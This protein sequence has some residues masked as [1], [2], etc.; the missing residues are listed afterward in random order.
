MATKGTVFDIKRFAIH[1]GPGIRTIVFLKG[2]PLRCPW[3]QNPESMLL[4]PELFF[5]GDACTGCGTCAEA[6]TKGAVRFIDGRRTYVRENCVTCGECSRQCP[7][8]ALTLVGR[9]MDSDEVA[10]VVERDRPFYDKSGGGVT[11]SGGEPLLQKQFAKEILKASHERGI[12]TALDTCAVGRWEDVVEVLRY[13]DL[14]L[15]DVKLIEPIRHRDITGVDN[16]QILENVRKL[17]RMDVEVVVRIPVIPGIN[18]DEDNV[19]RTGSFL[20]K[21]SNVTLVELLPYNRFAES[22]YTRFGLRYGLAGLE[23]QTVKRMNEIE[24]LLAD[25]GLPVATVWGTVPTEA[26]DETVSA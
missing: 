11:V 22:K 9:V 4:E 14:V 18:D 26:S 1:D 21:M 8:G 5:S 20:R 2:C 16:G 15:L 12:H 24:R 25:S 3:C 23:T 6:C 19:S 7:G 13:T 17:A 10:D